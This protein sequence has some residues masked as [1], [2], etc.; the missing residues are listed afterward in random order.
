MY[1][2]TKS[3]VWWH[4]Y[5]PSCRQLFGWN[6][7]TL[8]LLKRT[9]RFRMNLVYSMAADILSITLPGHLKTWYWHSRIKEAF[10]VK[11]VGDGVVIFQHALSPKWEPVENANIILHFSTYIQYKKGYV[12]YESNINE[13]IPYFMW[14]QFWKLN[15]YLKCY[16]I[17]VHSPDMKCISYMHNFIPINWNFYIKDY[18]PVSLR[19]PWVCG[20]SMIQSNRLFRSG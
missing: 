9:E 17:P 16:L 20:A 10:C 15:E 1:V 5:G 12:Y 3:P 2:F 19:R 14:F 11:V 7:S 8:L 6:F 13:D 4:W 18:F